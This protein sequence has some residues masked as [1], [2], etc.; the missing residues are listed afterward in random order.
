MPADEEEDFGDAW[1]EMGD[2]AFFDAPTNDATASTS[3][4]RSGTKGGGSNPVAYD[5]G[6]EPD[7]AG[8]LNAQA[9]AK[10]KA[11]NP[12][13]RGLAKKTESLNGG[14]RPSLA[15]RSATTGKVGL[16]SAGKPS[17][18]MGR[19]ATTMTTTTTTTRKVAKP[20]DTRPK[21]EGLDDDG[22]GWGD[23]W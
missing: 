4:I 15:P 2:E 22:D 8:W 9:Q 6:G 17:A 11:T 14:T 7:F 10:S 12:L 23:G 3:P 1:A 5:D 18:G 20:L 21:D 19:G 16:A 13:P